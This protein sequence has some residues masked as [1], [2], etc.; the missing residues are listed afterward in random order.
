M[1][2]IFVDSSS[3]PFCSVC[4]ARIDLGFLIDGSKRVQRSQLQRITKYVK[5]VLRRFAVSS[6]KTRVGIVVFSSKSRVILTFKQ[7]VG[8]R[9][10]SRTIDRIR[11]GRGVRRIGRALYVAGR[12]LYRGKPVC[13]TR[14]VLIVI[15]TGVSVDSVRRPVKRLQASGVELYVVGV[16][17]VSRRYLL[18]IGT[19]TKH[20]LLAGFRSLLT[21]TRTIKEKICNS[22]GM[23]LLLVVELL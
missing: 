11:K 5:E 15:T 17:R 4:T 19:D 1:K 9:I 23:S 7:T 13:G 2:D 21:I 8:Q 10:L 6:G 14:R 18:Q 12:K 3:F 16:G 22:P 20:V